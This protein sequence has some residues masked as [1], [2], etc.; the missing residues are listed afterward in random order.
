M[1]GATF[2]RLHLLFDKHADEKN[3]LIDK[4]AERVQTLGGIAVATLRTSP[5]SPKSAMLRRLSRSSSNAL[6]VVGSA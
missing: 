4:I 5:S 2:Y 6:P 1:R 3:E